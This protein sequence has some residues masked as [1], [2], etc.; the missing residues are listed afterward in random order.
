MSRGVYRDL[1]KDTVQQLTLNFAQPLLGRFNQSARSSS[2]EH[3]S[4]AIVSQRALDNRAF[5]LAPICK[6]QQLPFGQSEP[7]PDG[8]K[9]I[10]RNDF[11][12]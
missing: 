4:I 3:P 11:N 8:C 12:S 5:Q 10:Q 6:P 7:Q 9:R 2:L 1:F